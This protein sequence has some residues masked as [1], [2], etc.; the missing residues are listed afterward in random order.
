[1]NQT[2]QLTMDGSSPVIDEEYIHIQFQFG[3]IKEVG[4]NGT[5]LEHMIDILVARLEG[6]QNGPFRCRENA[7]A[8]TKL[9]EARMWLLER[10]RKRQAQ[11]VEGINAPHKE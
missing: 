4:V 2:D 1:M 6:F 7:L 9:E 8:I 10:T 5:T 3:P 11:G